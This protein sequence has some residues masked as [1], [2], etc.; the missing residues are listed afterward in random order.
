MLSSLPVCEL[1]L[2][3]LKAVL[4]NYTSCPDQDGDEDGR[5][6]M[7]RGGGCYNM[8]RYLPTWVVYS[9]LHIAIH[10]SILFSIYF[11]PFVASIFIPCFW[12]ISPFF[13][14]LLFLLLL[15][16]LL[17]LSSLSVGSFELK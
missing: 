9:L 12:E 10:P 3:K 14:L 15:L 7:I 8:C 16:L 13:L 4:L 1:L 5:T 6:T 17:L 2:D 11:S